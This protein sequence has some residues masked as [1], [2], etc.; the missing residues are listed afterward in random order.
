MIRFHNNGEWSGQGALKGAKGFWTR[1]YNGRV[2]RGV[3][4]GDW[5][6]CLDGG[7]DSPIFKTRSELSDW[8]RKEASRAL[9]ERGLA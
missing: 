8:L 1:H 5:Q 6:G 4:L 9:T 3:K 2:D 7:R